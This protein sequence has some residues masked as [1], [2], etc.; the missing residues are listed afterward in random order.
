[1]VYA[2]YLTFMQELCADLLGLYLYQDYL[3]VIF[4][5]FVTYQ[6]LS[7]LKQDHTKH[8]VFASYSYFSLFAFSYYFSCTILFST[9]LMLT[10]VCLM[11]C[12]IIHQRQLQKNFVLPSTKYATTK[13]IP[14][15][16]WID[17]L[18]QS[19]LIASHH[20]KHISCILE[21]N[22][23]IHSLL[24]APFV[25]QLPIQKDITDLLLASTNIHDHSLLWANHSGMIQSIN[26]S[27]SSFLLNEL[28]ITS[29]TDSSIIHHEAATLLTQKTDALVFEIN[30]TKD[31]NTIWYQGKCM[32][33]V[34]V[35]QLL[36][37]VKEV[38]HH[39]QPPKPSIKRKNHDQTT[40]TTS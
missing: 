6:C 15:K 13:T 10:P 36:I 37:F 9:L 39:T 18:I 38:L 32:Q 12:I 24:H 34:T 14:H 17:T 33:H 27:W 23:H 25:L 19:C 16:N 30:T 40:H 28:F 31:T 1:M 5:I 29:K 20:N 11:L 4:F 21:R 8:L 22:D 26:V 7:W 35:Q 2:E 3:E